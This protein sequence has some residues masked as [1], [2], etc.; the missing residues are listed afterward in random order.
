M[1]PADT[2]AA[3]VSVIQTIVMM[4]I[5][6]SIVALVWFSPVWSIG[7]TLV[8]VF[9]TWL[10]VKT[11]IYKYWLMLKGVGFGGQDWQLK[12]EKMAL[13]MKEDV[14]LDVRRSLQE[15]NPLTE[16]RSK[17][18][19]TRQPSDDGMWDMSTCVSVDSA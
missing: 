3:S 4:G 13:D 14:R 8:T 2:N 7:R 10:A 16:T 6:T 5:L 12:L 11:G 15:G 9:S 18:K 17:G 1:P 19:G